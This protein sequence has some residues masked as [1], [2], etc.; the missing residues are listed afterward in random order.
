MYLRDARTAGIAAGADHA[1]N[2]QE[3]DVQI[4]VQ[5]EVAESKSVVAAEAGKADPR[6]ATRAR[7]SRA[8]SLRFPAVKGRA[9][10][11]N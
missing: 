3:A 9:R 6:A 5:R 4:A 1:V 8:D 11:R 2:G 7:V 10:V